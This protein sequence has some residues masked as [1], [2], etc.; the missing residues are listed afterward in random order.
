MIREKKFYNIAI[1]LGLLILSFLMIISLAEVIL[2]NFTNLREDDFKVNIKGED[3]YVSCYSSN[4]RGYLQ[5]KLE[6][7]GKNLY[8]INYDCTKRKMGFFPERKKEIAIVGDSFAFGEGVKDEDTLGYLLGLEFT[9]A[10]FKNY[11]KKGADIAGIFSVFLEL[12]Q[13]ENNIG[14]IVYFYNLNDV[15]LSDEV[16]AQQKYIIDFQTIR[17]ERARRPHNFIASALSKSTIYHLVENSIIFG[18]ESRLTVK[19]YM[20]MYF[21]PANKA[22]LNKTLATILL[23][24]KIAKERKVNFCVV[25]YPL[26]YKDV[27]GKYPFL[28]I[29]RLI[30]DFCRQKNIACIDAYPAFQ[31][32]YSLNKFIV[33]AVDY[34]PNGLANEAVVEYLAQRGDFLEDYK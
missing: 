30:K 10:N 1:N 25:I 16:S 15:L 22:E 13:S 21:S 8:C 20:D 23:M 11:G 29:H 7:N 14:E 33:Q 19:N 6:F 2:Y 4:P 32:Y 18:K 28:A 24:D 27:F 31:K 3:C 5:N 9:Q 12:L 17:W 34:H 26:L